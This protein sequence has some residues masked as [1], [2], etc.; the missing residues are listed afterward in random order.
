VLSDYYG[1]PTT[2]NVPFFM[3]RTVTDLGNR[4]EA[5][6]R[7]TYRI[8]GGVRGTFNDDWS[9]EVSANYGELDETTRVL[10]NVDVQ[11]FLL[12]IDAVRDPVSGNIV[13]RSTID[14]AARIPYENAI[15][16]A[17]AQAPISSRGLLSS[18]PMTLK[19]S[20]IQM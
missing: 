16:T 10:G 18:W 9:Y 13:C 11:R 15:N 12:A 17:A 3:T 20:C 2:A 1:V 19:V 6:R 4:D 7:D 14:P 8:V 5:A